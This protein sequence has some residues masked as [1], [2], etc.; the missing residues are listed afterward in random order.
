MR[1]RLA[2]LGIIGLTVCIPVFAHPTRVESGFQ[3]APFSSL[4]LVKDS[5]PVSGEATYSVLPSVDFEMSL[6]IRDTSRDDGP[7]LR[8]AL[9][10]GFSGYGG[11]AY[12]EWPRDQFGGWDVGAGLSLH[13]NVASFL[14]PYV[15]LGRFESEDLS[16]FVRN[17]VTF[18]APSD[19]TRWSVLWIPTVGV[20]RHRMFQQHALFLSAI[21]GS[22]RAVEQ[23]CFFDCETSYLRTRV[24]LGASFS[25]TLLTPYRPGV[26]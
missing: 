18:A 16:W 6:G 12:V 2:L 9:D 25:F 10:A 4:A 7:G 11:S 24:M 1:R 13:R 22:Q 20:V 14:T 19:S 3:L 8:L 17:G 26:R 23:P 21:V 5:M 15:Q